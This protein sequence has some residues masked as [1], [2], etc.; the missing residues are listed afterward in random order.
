MNTSSS[1]SSSTSNL[2]NLILK[3]FKD[4]AVLKETKSEYW[5]IQI[6]N[7]LDCTFYFAMISIAAV[8]LS[9][10]IGLSDEY[11][12]YS[13]TLFTTATTIFLFF[14]GMFTDWLG[15]KK[16]I[17]LSMISMFLL[18]LGVVIGGLYEIPY[19][20][21]VVTVLL[22]LMAPFMAMMQTVFQA[23]NKRYTTSKSRSAGFSLWYLF[24][25]VGAAGGGFLIDIIRK[26]LQLSNTHIFTSG[27]LFALLCII[28][29]FVFIRSEA[30]LVEE[31]EE[32]PNSSDQSAKLKEREITK[33]N[34]IQIAYEVL[35]ESAF[36]KLTVVITLLLGV[37]AIF[38]YMYLLM[39]KYW[40]RVIGPTAA[41]G[42]LQAIN[43]ILIIIG[44]ILFIPFV[45]KF[46]LFKM[47]IYGA[48]ISSLSLFMLV[49]PWQWFSSDIGTAHY[50]MSI[51]ALILLS[52]GEVIWSP[53]LTEYTA[54][55]A[56]EGQEGTYLGLTMV[57]WFLAKTVVSVL[58][59]HILSRWCPEGI[60]EPMLNNTIS[61]WDSPAAMWLILGLVAFGGCIIALMLKK[62]LTAGTK[63]TC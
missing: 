19:R 59:G 61:F 13:I 26:G 24:M 63:V 18:R 58:S 36:W 53:K 17:Y 62:W 40:L 47:L 43:P 28:A 9:D 8:F 44:I 7:F 42:S 35:Q 15:I 16:S 52:I 33:K 2:L 1:S 45:N 25:N 31:N 54:Q 23:A 14:S 21:I 32:I 60:R 27:L 41:I 22:F 20:G 11:A 38:T 29:C 4:F 56:P 37:R 5:G 30:Q 51:S 34:P 55:I 49:L 48:M 10:N 6:I 39:P 3:Y 46:N 12:G 57:P 50:I